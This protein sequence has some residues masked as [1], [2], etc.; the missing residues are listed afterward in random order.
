[1]C[2]VPFCKVYETNHGDK[3]IGFP[4][5]TGADGDTIHQWVLPIPDGV[6]VDV[7]AE[8]LNQAADHW[9]QNPRAAKVKVMDS[10]P[11][12]CVHG[13]PADGICPHCLGEAGGDPANSVTVGPFQVFS[14]CEGRFPPVTV[15]VG[16]AK[17]GNPGLV[18]IAVKQGGAV[19]QQYSDINLHG[20]EIVRVVE[21]NTIDED[22]FPARVTLR[23]EIPIN[24]EFEPRD[25]DYVQVSD[26]EQDALE[27]L[28]R[29]V[30][31]DPKEE[32]GYPGEVFR[33]VKALLTEYHA[34]YKAAKAYCNT[35]EGSSEEFEALSA[36]ADAV[37]GVKDGGGIQ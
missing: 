13:R 2:L 33:H 24:G 35:V 14:K 10:D 27:L 28:W 11:L 26:A 8:L 34:V 1:M 12:M 20:L 31:P 18:D 9:R 15:S 7:L 17:S 23:R 29:L 6:D 36:L 22:G 3:H 5:Q 4:T 19:L 30:Y 21:K 32:W 16:D 37:A 25:R